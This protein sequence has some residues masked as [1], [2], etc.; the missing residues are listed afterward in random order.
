MN[1]S[2][3]IINNVKILACWKYNLT[4]NTDCT[5]CRCNLNSPSIYNNDNDI[6]PLCHGIC[7]HVFHSECITPWLE[8]SNR[9]P[10]CSL[11]NFVPSINNLG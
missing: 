2:K 11:G 3:F 5:I 8:T 6:T 7:G 9:C 1:S 10:I 4:S